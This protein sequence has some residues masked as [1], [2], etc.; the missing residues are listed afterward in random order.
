M[1]G[2]I[3][4]VLR[5]EGG[6]LVEAQ[7]AAEVLS[8]RRGGRSSLQELT[9]REIAPEAITEAVSAMCRNAN[10]DLPADVRAALQ[11]AR[12]EETSGVAAE[13]LDTLLRNAEVAAAERLALCQDCGVAVFFVELG[14][15]VHLGGDLYAAINEGVRAGYESGYLRKS[16]VRDPLRRDTNTG[17][18]TPPVVHVRLVEGDR[19]RLTIAPKG[20]GSENMSAVWMLTPAEGREGILRRVTERI[21]EAGGK[22][23]PPL[24]LGVGV[25]GTMEKAALLAKEA[26]L[27][28]VGAPSPILE[29]AQLEQELLT[30]VNALGIGPMGLGGRTT[31]LAVHVERHPC[32][33]ASLPVALNVQ[34]HAARHLT[35]EL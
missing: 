7:P 4:V 25:G 23:C 5:R 9:M 31:A 13:V 24:I 18:N 28:E 21:A 34:C 16:M 29:V 35:V 19:L 11:R 2:I 30:R 8:A 33:I 26:L 3:G 32:H 20:G 1:R 10:Y 17:D 27:R 14:R 6:G 15:D 12:D 22:P